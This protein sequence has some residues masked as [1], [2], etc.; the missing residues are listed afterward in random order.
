M[1]KIDL[2]SLKSLM[3][4]KTLVENGTATRTAKVLGIT[5]SG[6]SRSLSQL[7]QN[8]GMQLFIRQKNRLLATPEAQELHD[9]I[10]RL[11][12]NLDELEHSVMALREF[13]ASRIGIAV[14]PG[15]G[16]GF[17]P[18]LIGRLRQV[19]PRLAIYLDIMSSHDV[20]HAV[21]A[22]A[23]DIGFVTLPITS[24]QLVVEELI[25]TE[26]VCLLPKDHPLAESDSIGP[27][28]LAG[29]HLVVP[30]QP[31]IAADQLLRLIASHGIRIAGKTEANIGSICSL[32]GNGVGLSVINPIT[33][34]DLAHEGMVAKP[35]VPAIHYAFG[36]VYQE[37]W[38]DNNTVAQIRQNL[39]PVS[40]Y[41]LP[42]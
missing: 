42:A 8:L 37:K 10:L 39:P 30:N 19:N 41:L 20:V 24:N 26:A 40:E 3:I 12:S 22:G 7:E 31:N 38:R 18:A 6:V 16:F 11:V 13:G 2:H 33:A 5:Q 15:L 21:E 17:I 36:M 34:L 35:F 29:Q 27:E 14:I 9:E 1:D 28:Q 32:V 25:E 4:F 23:F